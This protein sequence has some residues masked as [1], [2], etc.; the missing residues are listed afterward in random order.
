MSMPVLPAEKPAKVEFYNS[1]RWSY[2]CLDCAMPM[3][4][5]TYNKCSFNCLY[6]FSWFQK[7][8]TN[9]RK[10][11][12]NPLKFNEYQKGSLKWLDIRRLRKIFDTEHKNEYTE[13]IKKRITLQIGGLADCFD[14]YEHRKG[15]TLEILQFLDE[16]DY[17]I[18]FSTKSVWFTKDERYMALIRKHKHNWHFKFSIINLD[19]EKAR[20]MEKGVASPQERL[21]AMKRLS[22]EGIHTTLRLRPFIIGYTD[23]NNEYLTL[24][25]LAKEAGAET[26][27]TEFFCFDERANKHTLA[28]YKE[29]SDIMGFDVYKFY[30]NNSSGRGL[31]RLNYEIK[32]PYIKAMREQCKKVGLG[33]YVS[34]A[35][36]KEECET[37]GCCGIPQTKDFNYQKGQFTEAIVIAK[38]NGIVKWSDIEPEARILKNVRMGDVVGAKSN[39]RN[40]KVIG[41]T[42][43]DMMKNAW[44]DPK[45]ARGPYIYFQGILKP[46]GLDDNGDIIY[47]YKGEKE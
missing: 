7:T 15:K 13:L 14:Y 29:M 16:I 26:I 42:A 37:G 8:V 30:K 22:D 24:I 33:F 3:T 47:E 1:P 23:T 43:Y 31:L 36:H 44:N 32:T 4:L 19:A 38:R 21:A 46:K 11:K 39:V 5:D 2:E 25:E 20:K 6:C 27:S 45:N 10:A 17:P 34:D 12:N 9:T 40:Q 28:R 41:F 18:S 35:H